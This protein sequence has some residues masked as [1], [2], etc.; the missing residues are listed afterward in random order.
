MLNGD[1]NENN[2]SNKQK[3]KEKF[4]TCSTLF[5]TFFCR[6][7]CSI[8]TLNYLFTRFMEEI[9]VVCAQQKFGCLCSCS[10]FLL[11]FFF[12][13]AAHFHLTGRQQF[14]LHFLTAGIKFSLF[15]QRNSSP[16][17]FV[18]LFV[19][20]FISGSRSFLCYPHQRKARAPL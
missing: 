7:C 15:F 10:R 20:F 17:F 5:C 13:T 1:G 4:C 3:K 14:S 16:L 11:F 18:C 9:S 2:W 8:T 12:F 6:C 19:C